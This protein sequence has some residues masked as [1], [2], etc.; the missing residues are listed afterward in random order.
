VKVIY[1][2]PKL[3]YR[4]LGTALQLDPE[5]VYPAIWARNIPDWKER[6][7]VYVGDECGIMLETGEYTIIKNYKP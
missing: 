1:V 4:L 7:L 6:G 2:R 5:K 3:P